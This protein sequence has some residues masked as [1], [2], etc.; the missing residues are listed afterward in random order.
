MHVVNPFAISGI[1]LELLLKKGHSDCRFACNA[2]MR[3]HQCTITRTINTLYL[4]QEAEKI[5]EKIDTLHL[6]FAKRAAPFNNWMDGAKEDLVD[7][8][9]V[10]TTEEIQVCIFIIFLAIKLIITLL[11]TIAGFDICT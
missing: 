11:I 8:F 1:Y 7:M 5:L 3:C 2:N 10:H 6:E 9:I 4:S